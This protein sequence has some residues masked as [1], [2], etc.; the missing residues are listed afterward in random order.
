MKKILKGFDNIMGFIFSHFGGLFTLIILII[1]LYTILCRYVLHISTGGLDEFSSYFVVSSVF[2][3]SVLAVRDLN[4]GPVKIDLLDIF[5]KNKKVMHVINII[6]Q[7]LAI[8]IMGLYSKLAFQYFAYQFKRGST[9]AGI[10]FPMWVF[11][12]FMAFC[13]V[14]ITIYELRKLIVLIL[15]LA[16]K[17]TPEEKECDK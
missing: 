3:G 13:S 9:L 17:R 4:E 6:W 15:E 10:R 2:A 8:C 1:V 11:T 5:I 12:G 7:I 14:F 16:G